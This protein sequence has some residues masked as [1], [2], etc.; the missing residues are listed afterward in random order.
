MSDNRLP[1]Q[2]Y[3]VLDE[4]IEHVLNDQ[5]TIDQCL[6]DYPQYADLLKAELQIALLTR[7]LK[8]PGMNS[9]KIDALEKRLD[10][11]ARHKSPGSTRIVRLPAI[12]RMAASIIL[13]FVIL[14]SGTG[15]VIAASSSS[16]PNDT[17]YGVKRTWENIVILIHSVTGI[18]DDL[19]L[20][21]A[22][23][24]L[25]EVL[26]LADDG[27]LSDQALD[28]LQKA[29][30]RL[31]DESE[32]LPEILP[33]LEDAQAMLSDETIIPTEKQGRAQEI[34]VIV[35]I[36]AQEEAQATIDDTQNDD[37]LLPSPVPQI[38]S[39]ETDESSATYTLTP[40]ATFT[41]SPTA[42]DTPT[43]TETL[44]ETITASAT[45]TYTPTLTATETPRI[46]PTATDTPSPTPSFTP[47]LVFRVMTLTP[48]E[49]AATPIILP[50]LIPSSTM[51]AT[52]T[53][54]VTAL[55]TWYPWTQATIDALYATRTAEYATYE[56][57]TGT[58]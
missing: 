38:T 53:P 34:I 1:L 12:S 25:D 2:Y 4:C 43:P 10:S 41:L 15:G 8:T 27:E 14:V 21:L 32:S 54:I 29:T 6:N 39:T 19:W 51:P 31:I 28:E 40:T 3:D 49:P 35:I 47:S 58:P 11:Q 18:P 56:A 24:R 30:Q 33:F 36:P 26:A 42:T 57:Q 55:P 46:P 17:L 9:T 13:V 22:Q 52:A 23:T 37:P 5:R 50:S 16:N 20:Q 7:R 44:T 48:T 45:I